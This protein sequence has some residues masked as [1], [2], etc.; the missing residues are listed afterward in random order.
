MRQAC[1]QKPD[2]CSR[3]LP[4]IRIEFAGKDCPERAALGCPILK[5]R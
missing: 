4:A 5:R 2:K 1:E 3:I